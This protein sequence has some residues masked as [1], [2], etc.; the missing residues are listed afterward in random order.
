MKK[1]GFTLIELLIVITIILILAA[2]LFPIFE[3]VRE[4]ARATICMNNLK[5]LGAA[6][7]MYMDDNEGCLNMTSSEI[8]AW[9]GSGPNYWEGY[10]TNYPN[11]WVYLL[12]PDPV[13]PKRPKYIK[14]PEVFACPSMLARYSIRSNKYRSYH[15]SIGLCD[16]PKGKK[17]MNYRQQD[18]IVLLIESRLMGP[19]DPNGLLYQ[20]GSNKIWYWGYTYATWGI[21]SVNDWWPTPFPGV[22]GSPG[23]ANDPKSF[24]YTVFLDGHFD[25]IKGPDFSSVFVESGGAGPDGSFSNTK[26]PKAIIVP[27]HYK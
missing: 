12:Y 26:D 1:K 20:S 9:T 18:K 21:H 17:V 25:I 3:K 4:K 24:Y 22:H 14:S 6:L 7:I 11:F 5:Q 23:L 2:I 15:M 8:T 10:F 13:D 27:S 19:I 16:G